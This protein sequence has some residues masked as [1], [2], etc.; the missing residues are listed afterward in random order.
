MLREHWWQDKRF[1]QIVAQHAPISGRYWLS[2]GDG[3]TDT[4]VRH[5]PTGMHQ[6]VS[7][8]AGV[9]AAVAALERAGAT[10]HLERFEGGHTFAPWRAEL[11][12]ALSWLWQPA[13]R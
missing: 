10:V 6:M 1:A 9:E 12:R 11:P 13:A 2:V 4:D 5:P 7:Q 8:I 3:E